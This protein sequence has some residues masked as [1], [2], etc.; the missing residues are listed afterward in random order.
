MTWLKDSSAM[1]HA[2]KR[3]RHLRFSLPKEAH[4]LPKSRIAS[5]AIRVPLIDPTAKNE[6]P[7]IED[8]QWSRSKAQGE[9]VPYTTQLSKHWLVIVLPPPHTIRL[10]PPREEESSYTL[11][12]LTLLP[13]L[14]LKV[15]EPKNEKSSIDEPPEVELK[16]LPPH[17]E[18]AFLEGTDKLPVITAKDL[19]D[20]EKAALIK[21]LKSHKQTIAWK[22]SDIKGINPKFYAHN[23]L[24]EDDFKPAVQH[25]RRVNPKI[26]EVIKKEV[27]KLLDVGL[28]YPI[29][30][31]PWVSPVHY[32]P[33]KGGFIVVENEENELIPTRLVTGWRVCID[34]Q[35]LNDATRKDHFPL[36]FMDQMLERLAGKEY[37]CFLDGFSGYFQIP[38][39]PQD[40]E[41]TTFT[42]P[43]GTFAYHRERIFKK[44]TKRKPKTNKTKHGME[45]SKSIRHG[46][47]SLDIC[48][49]DPRFTSKFLEVISDSYGYSAGNRSTAYI[50]ECWKSERTIYQTLKI[51]LDEYIMMDNSTVVEDPVEILVREIKK[52][53]R[54]VFPS[55]KFDGTPRE[56]LSLRGNA[57]ISSEKSIC[58]SLQRPHPR[59]MLHLEPW[60]KALLAGGD[61]LPSTPG[62]GDTPYASIP[63]TEF[64]PG[65]GQILIFAPICHFSC[66]VA[67]MYEVAKVAVQGGR[68]AGGG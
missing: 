42:C 61:A 37:Y 28:I 18:Y 40:Q 63:M 29:S 14:E 33:K 3:K 68:V 8:I 32:V 21:V 58:T 13:N 67:S 11:V 51:W 24:M 46:I 50:R 25:Q 22:L 27:L 20:Q 31:S 10:P 17:L 7:M 52:Y 62:K 34:Y 15:V 64:E 59:R 1:L 54:S 36:L 6:N 4:S 9:R 48:D 19:K 30:D 38:I 16:D 56:V 47:T 44:R 43:Y 12:L 23:I 45:K 2:S 5:L 53:G 35:K 57:K 39:D 66:H 65:L 55:S 41:K 49:R 26:H 60:D